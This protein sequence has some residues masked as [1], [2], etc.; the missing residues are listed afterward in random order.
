MNI[1][2]RYIFYLI[3]NFLFRKFEPENYPTAPKLFIQSKRS[4]SNPFKF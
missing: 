3:I 4:S 1:T 2:D